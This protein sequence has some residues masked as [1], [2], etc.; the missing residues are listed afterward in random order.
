LHWEK[1]PG[2]IVPGDLTAEYGFAQSQKSGKYSKRRIGKQMNLRMPKAT[3]PF[4]IQQK[5][6]VNRGFKG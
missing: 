4:A 1:T 2:V 3:F 6:P 5:T